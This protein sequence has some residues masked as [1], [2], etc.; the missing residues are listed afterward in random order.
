MPP[1]LTDWLLSLSS[2]KHILGFSIFLLESSLVMYVLLNTSC[3]S[4]ALFFTVALIQLLGV[5]NCKTVNG[6]HG[7]SLRNQ[8]VPAPPFSL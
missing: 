6:S 5:D 7:R 8:V 1:P 4:L 3:C 2:D